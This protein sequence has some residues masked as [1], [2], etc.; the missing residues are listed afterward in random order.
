MSAPT[1]TVTRILRVLTLGSS[2][3]SLVET[4]SGGQW[5][6]K[7]AGAGPGR[8]AL[9]TEYIALKLARHLGLDVPDARLFDLPPDFP[10]DVGTDEFYEAVQRSAGVNLGIAFIPEAV[11]LMAAELASLPPGFLDRLATFDAL[12]QNVDRTMANPNIIRDAQAHAWAIDFGACLLIDRLARGKSEPRLALPAN[13][14]LAA[15]AGAD[16]P[17]SA[18]RMAAAIERKVIAHIVRALPEAW[19][20]DLMLTHDALLSR[21][22][23][24]VETVASGPIQH[25]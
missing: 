24:Y 23:N 9:A 17:A 22:A 15:G 11:D 20:T 3:P 5:V 2:F 25:E 19:L 7:L 4:A 10:W 21:L 6:M 12:L 1:E 16:V 8:R 13:H 14:F 18:S